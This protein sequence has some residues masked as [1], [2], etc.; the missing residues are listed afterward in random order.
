MLRLF[1]ALKC[2]PPHMTFLGKPAA[3]QSYLLQTFR[4]SLSIS[5]SPRTS[6]YKL[7]CPIQASGIDFGMAMIFRSLWYAVRRVK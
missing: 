1:R 4:N 3:F 2:S 6:D 7:R 5:S